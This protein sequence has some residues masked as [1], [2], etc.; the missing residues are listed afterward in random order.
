MLGER[1]HLASGKALMTL[2]GSMFVISAWKS[3]DWPQQ[4]S[5]ILYFAKKKFGKVEGD[6][7]SYCT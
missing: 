1:T 2:R 7:D 4:L 3:R 6:N 5:N